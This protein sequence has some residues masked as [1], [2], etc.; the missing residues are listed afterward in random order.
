MGSVL[1]SEAQL[2]ATYTPKGYKNGE[3]AVEA[4]REWQ[5]WQSQHPEA[6][7]RAASDALE[8]P[9][10]RIRA[11]QDGARPDA[12]RGIE[13]A[14][15]RG[16]VDVEPFSAMG[17]AL[18]RLLAW[19]YSNGSVADSGGRRVP[20]FVVGSVD[21]YT[22]F[23]EV[24]RK[25]NLEVRYVHASES[26]RATEAE[27]RDG[28]VFGRVLTVLGAV[29]GPKAQNIHRL[30]SVVHEYWGTDIA[31]WFADTYITNRGHRDDDR[32]RWIAIQEER[33]EA[34]L[35]E[36]VELFEAVYDV[37]IDRGS[38]NIYLPAASL[39]H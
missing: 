21:E 15:E 11:W 18:T 6:G 16:W 26:G 14:R 25:A 35:D 2:A 9:E 12:V 27:P 37:E 23:A 3:A 13:T 17:E 1:V 34:Y 24:A 22:R 10:G 4:Y 31:R 30:P 39:P 20:R 19:V 33:S 5:A 38:K 28:M 8:M 7:R 29:P 36:V 32:P